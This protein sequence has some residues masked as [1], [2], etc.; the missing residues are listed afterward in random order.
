MERTFAKSELL[1]T[2]RAAK[3]ACEVGTDWISIVLVMVRISP[4]IGRGPWSTGW[5][6]T[7]SESVSTLLSQVYELD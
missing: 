5:V 7:T 1:F 3:E 2:H 4:S 6:M